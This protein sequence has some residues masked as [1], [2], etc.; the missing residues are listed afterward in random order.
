M[1]F[2][3][4]YL[5]GPMRNKIIVSYEH[6]VIQILFRTCE[7]ISGGLIVFKVLHL[8]LNKTC[9]TKSRVLRAKQYVGICL[10][11]KKGPKKVPLYYSTT[12]PYYAVAKS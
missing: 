11:N 9:Q 3:T 12:C 7:A 6:A 10:A 8:K 4:S 2:R 1:L 5:G